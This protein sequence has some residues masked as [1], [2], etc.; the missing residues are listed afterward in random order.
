MVPRTERKARGWS[1]TLR[2]TV[3]LA[4][5][6]FFVALLL[7]FLGADREDHQR[8]VLAANKERQL[9]TTL[10]AR[11]APLLERGDLMRL[12]VLAA[13]ARDQTDG[14]V[15]VLDRNG[16]VVLDTAL[17]LGERQLGLLSGEGLY[18]RTSVRSAGPPVRETLAPV[19]FGG[20]LIGE[21][22]LQRE[23]VATA[24]Q[25]D[26]TWFG[27]VLLS[28]LTL[29]AVA[30]IMGHHW[31]AR[32]RSA[33]DALIRLSAGEVAGVASDPAEG[34]LQDLDIALRQMERGVQDG[35]QR[36]GEGYVAMALQ[37]VEGLEDRRL[38]PPGHGERT[39]QLAAMLCERLQLLPADR[40]DID[41]AG[42]LVDLGKAAVR[43]SILQKED[44][45]TEL[46]AQSLQ[47]H[48]VRAAEQLECVPGLRRVAQIL[49]HQSER[50][51]GKGSPD[52][53]RGDRIPI[54]SRIL[55]IASSFDLLITCADERPLDWEAALAQ[56][57]FARGDVFDPWLLELF[58]EEVRRN[59]PTTAT[60]RPVMIV[61]AGS[62]PWRSPGLAEYQVED[63]SAFDE[64][65]LEVML[66]ERRHE[67]G[68]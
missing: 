54:G 52:G 56:L 50:Y 17:V 15:L 43:V 22:R 24:A 18:Q 19:R 42:R 45:L 2:L 49:R 67:E 39:A 32:V 12:S 64:D 60:D 20:E 51:D 29:V 68:A 27:L 11:A 44:Q 4:A 5:G 37:V 58:E 48:P 40:A 14:R 30:A 35:L 57:G 38:A 36:V 53:L 3:A 31:S 63:E 33:T 9:A 66:E 6:A 26:F 34:E 13:V 21:L 65:D 8:T 28:C 1:L 25:F 41:I 61:P 7:G 23:V 10:A 46:E 59:P 16:R 62:M 47:N 55:A